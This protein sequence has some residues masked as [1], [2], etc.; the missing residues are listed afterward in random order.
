AYYDPNLRTLNIAICTTDSSALGQDTK[1]RITNLAAGAKYRVLMDG[2]EYSHWNMR[3][4]A[5]EIR[6]TVG[7]HS[8]IVQQTAQ[9]N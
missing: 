8:L 1:F 9:A 4:G 2:E 5:L 3:D 6:T 7:T